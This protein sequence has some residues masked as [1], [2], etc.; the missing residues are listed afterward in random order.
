MATPLSVDAKLPTVRILPKNSA[1][2]SK[3]SIHDDEKARQMGYKGGLVPGVT[4][5]GYMSRLMQ[6]TFGERWQS[7]STF[8]GRLRRPV[9]EGVEVTVEGIVIEAPSA[10]NENTVV[11]ELKVIDADGVVAAFAQASCKP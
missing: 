1:A 9:Y 2:E 11:V 4:V 7:G 10:E 3:G 8:A 5:L 6:E